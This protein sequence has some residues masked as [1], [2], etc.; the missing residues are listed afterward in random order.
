[1]FGPNL[2]TQVVDHFVFNQV[3]KLLT[4]SSLKLTLASRIIICNHV[5]HSTLWF[6][7]TVQL[8]NG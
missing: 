4:M 3:Y 2:N 1:M 8:R 5:L 6:F 7:T